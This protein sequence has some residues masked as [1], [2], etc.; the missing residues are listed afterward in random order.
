MKKIALFLLTVSSFSL[1]SGMFYKKKSP[2]NIC[3][4]ID[5]NDQKAFD[6]FLSK[7]YKDQELFEY[8][9]LP[10]RLPSKIWR[11]MGRA[12]KNGNMYALKRL[13]DKGADRGVALEEEVES[14][15]GGYILGPIS[16]LVY[17]L[18]NL[19][20]KPYRFEALDLLFEHGVDVHRDPHHLIQEFPLDVAIRF[21]DLAAGEYLLKKGANPC[22]ALEYVKSRKMLALLKR[23]LEP[24]KLKNKIAETVQER[25]KVPTAP[26]GKKLERNFHSTVTELKEDELSQSSLYAQPQEVILEEM[27]KSLIQNGELR[28]RK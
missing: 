21:K 20:K 15:T 12:L 27:T 26:L 11:P 5:R 16:P 9:W 24:Q 4:A 10:S 18:S 14:S 13:L 7:G 1:L 25:E 22:F 6:D 23:F 2:K 8:P 28:K 19:R 3:E 17:L